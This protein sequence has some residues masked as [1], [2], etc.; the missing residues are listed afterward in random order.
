[1]KDNFVKSILKFYIPSIVSFVLGL[2]SAIILT[3][4][5]VPEIYGTLN[6]FNNTVALILS[7]SY[8]GFDTAYIRFYNEPPKNMSKTQLCYGSMNISIKILSI[9]AFI[10]VV[11]LSDIFMDKIFGFRS[12][13]VCLAI[14]INVLAQLILRYFTI[15]YRMDLDTRKYSLI[16][17]IMQ[18]ATKFSVLIAAI[19]TLKIVNIL[20]INSVGV[21]IMAIIMATIFSTTLIPKKKYKGFIN[22]KEIVKFALFAAPVPIIVNLNAFIAQQIII[23]K[24][25]MDAAGVY[26]SAYYFTSMFTVL[27][28]GFAT[29]WGAYVYSNYKTEQ[30]TIKKMHDYLLMCIVFVYAAFILLKDIVY[31]LIGT[32]YQDSR[33]FFAMVLFYPMM[34][35]LT[36]TTGYGIQLGK[37]NHIYL[38]INLLVMVC[39]LSL[40]LI[41]L[42]VLGLK[43]IALASAISGLI[44]YIIATFF[45]QKYYITIINLKKSVFGLFVLIV[46][47]LCSGFLTG[48]VL[49]VVEVVLILMVSIIYHNEIRDILSI[50]K[51]FIKKSKQQ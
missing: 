11:F 34:V 20:V 23:N 5:F 17:I 24:L 44:H 22:E 8:L 4:V 35:L 7:V 18:I 48:L 49:N 13:V 21:I 25:S 12:R 26:S 45:G 10:V 16:T 46:M 9:V 1:M 36:E 37:K 2:L 27:Q 50:L 32:E 47:M 40:G 33:V 39:N 3:R 19:F 41:F 14:F 28:S 15:S 43:G 51:H 30:T 38:L 6:V 42:S 31:L 29:F